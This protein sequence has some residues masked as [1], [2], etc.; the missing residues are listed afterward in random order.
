MGVR[1]AVFALLAAGLVGLLA[2]PP[3]ARATDSVVVPASIDATGAS[4]A[5]AD[6]AA[7]IA[8]VPDGSTIAFA[9]GGT[10][11]LDTGLRLIDR[12]DLT[13]EGNGATLHATAA[14]GEPRTSPFVLEGGRNITLRGF[15]LTGT[16]PDSGTSES[17]HPDRQ[18]QGGVDAYGVRGLLIERT[19]IRET[20]GDC[21]YLGADDGTWSDGV[22]YRESTCERNGRMGVAIVAASNVLVEHVTFDAIAMFPFGIEPNADSEGAIGITIRDNEVGTY[23]HSTLFT[24]YFFVAEG[25]PG[26][27]VR[28]VTV[29]RNIVTGGT[30]ASTAERPNRFSFTFSDNVSLVPA[31]GPVLKLSAVQDLHVAGNVQPLVSGTLLAA[32]GPNRIVIAVL[33]AGAVLTAIAAVLVMLSF[34][35]RPMRRR[36]AEVSDL[37]ERGRAA[38]GTD[39]A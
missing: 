3:P 2:T 37:G 24:P 15:V 6:L 1:S 9:A 25:A 17:H 23:G 16:N 21:V 12:Q 4:D 38:T 5:S 22:T 14:T 11:R 10:Y 8:S 39:E 33:I 36:G 35:R 28:D 27:T 31:E 26:A 19:T 18:D 13:L 32:P 30:L 7:F 29:V 20:W 34:R